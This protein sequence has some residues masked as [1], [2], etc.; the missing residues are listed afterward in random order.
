MTGIISDLARAR[1]NVDMGR[2]SVASSIFVA[3]IGTFITASRSAAEPTPQPSGLEDHM[4]TPIPKSPLPV[5]SPE[6]SPTTG[7]APTPMKIADRN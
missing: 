3:V 4:G 6:P 1:E 2:I 5:P 7:P